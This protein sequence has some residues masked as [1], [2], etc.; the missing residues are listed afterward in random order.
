MSGTTG[1]SSGAAVVAD[2]Q[3]PYVTKTAGVCGGRPTIAGT[4]IAVRVVVGY[5]L[6]QDML[7]EEFVRLYPSTSLAQVYA[8][9][10]YYHDHRE[11][12]ER[13]ITENSRESVDALL[14]R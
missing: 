2:V 8:A 14:S 12:I 10:S 6:K 9:L 1:K 4:R 3:H 7:P 5:V 11:E 13:D